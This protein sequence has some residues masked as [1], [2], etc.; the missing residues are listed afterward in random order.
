M[1]KFEVR[2]DKMHP[3]MR[4]ILV[5]AII[6]LAVNISHAQKESVDDNKGSWQ[7]SSTW[8]DNAVPAINNIGSNSMDWNIYGYVTSRSQASPG[9][10]Y[11]TSNREAY[12]FTVYDTLVIYGSVQMAN[13]AM[14]FVIPAGGVVIIF[15]N[16]IFDNK[17]QIGSGGILVVT[18][19]VAFNGGSGQTDYQDNGGQFF[20]MGGISGTHIDADASAAAAASGPLANSG[21]TDII[22]FVGGGSPTL[23]PIELTS[24]EG[25]AQGEEAHLSWSTASQLN[26]SHFEVEQSV[27]ARDWNVLTSIA[28]EGTTNELKE[29]SFTHATPQNGKNYYRLRMVDLDDTFEYSDVVSATVSIG[30]MLSISPNPTTNRNARYTLNFTPSEGDQIVVY[31]LMGTVILVNNVIS[32]TDELVLPSS[33]TKGTYLVRYRGQSVN[34]TQ[35]LVVE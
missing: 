12:D 35:R 4:I 11:F 7:T 20:P 10:H 18:G 5:L 2:K 29:Y 6:S 26:F 3:K 25:I 13:K 27:N 14:N 15:G 23:L 16:L 24:F 8:T 28:G 31:D 33:L 34:Q 21:L 19:T 1:R 9:A 17:M 22:N 30:D 32:F